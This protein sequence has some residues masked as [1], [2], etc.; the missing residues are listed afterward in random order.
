MCDPL[1]HVSW[2]RGLLMKITIEISFTA[3]VILICPLVDGYDGVAGWKS[4]I[5]TLFVIK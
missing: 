1:M 3:A 5:A 2:W 4:S